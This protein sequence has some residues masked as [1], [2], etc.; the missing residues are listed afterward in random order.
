MPKSEFHF[1]IEQNFE[2]LS[3]HEASTGTRYT[4]EFNLISYNDAEPV[5]DLRNWTE[6]T[7]GTR[8]MGKGITLTLEELK[9]LKEALNE[10]Q[11]L[12]EEQ[13]S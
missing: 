11:D 3:E 1:E 13:V 6:N 9:V 4:K 10:L 5:Y 8:R 12:E 2:V 7:D